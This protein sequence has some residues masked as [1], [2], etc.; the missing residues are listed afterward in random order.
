MGNLAVVGKGPIEVIPA[1]PMAS[2]AADLM[3]QVGILAEFI[4]GLELNHTTLVLLATANGID[5]FQAGPGP[6]I[7]IEAQLLGP[8][9]GVPGVL[10]I[11]GVAQLKRGVTRPHEGFSRG[12][13]GMACQIRAAAL[14]QEEAGTARTGA[15]EIHDDVGL[16][17]KMQ[18][19]VYHSERFGLTS[20]TRIAG[21]S[22]QCP[23][24]SGGMNQ[25]E[26]QNRVLAWYDA[27][28]RKDLPWQIGRDPYRVWVSEIMLQ[29]TQVATVIPYFQRFIT[30]FPSVAHLA[31]ADLDEVIGLWAGLGYYARARNLHRAARII[32]ER[33]EAAFPNTLAELEALP[34][35]G[36]STAGAILSLG[37][38]QRA[39]ILDGNVKRVLCRFAGVEGWPGEPAVNRRLWELSESLTPM[40]RVA[41]YNQAMMDLGAMVCTRP[42]QP[43]PPA[44]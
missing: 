27:H 6:L 34:G 16:Y 8:I 32:L 40:E 17:S 31:A 24:K 44:R 12:R 18:R 21:G 19:G 2:E 5:D 13:R 3:E 26:F 22:V 36:R 28:G 1:S 41:D 43:V 10:D 23:V 4:L 11:F 35:I 39:A 14:A 20:Q 29:Q 9:D 30:R 42:A 37:L 33:H 7:L 25:D 38:G 15:G